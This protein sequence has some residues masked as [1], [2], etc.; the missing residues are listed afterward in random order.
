MR[1][2]FVLHFL[3]NSKSFVGYETIKMWSSIQRKLAL[4]IILHPPV[5]VASRQVFVGAGVLYILFG[6]FG[7]FSAL[8]ISIPYP[9]LGGAIVVMFG[10]F[11]G[12]II[13]NL[14]V[15]TDMRVIQRGVK[16]VL[17]S[18]Y[19]EPPILPHCFLDTD[20]LWRHL[21]D[22]SII[23]TYVIC[24][25]NN[26]TAFCILILCSWTSLYRTKLNQ[27]IHYQVQWISSLPFYP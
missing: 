8:F 14:E 20:A 12:V 13:S 9:V 1:I 2:S 7:K 21:F 11:F 10:I 3:P 22:N 15:S 6:V 24:F 4:T 17:S 19:L 27:F 26:E 18:V 5:Q 25:K 16:N 23:K